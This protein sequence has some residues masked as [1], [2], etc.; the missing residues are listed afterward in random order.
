MLEAAEVTKRFGGLLA[1]RG[2]TLKVRSGEI[3]GL[4]GPN[5]AGKTTLTNVISGVYAPTSGDVKLQGQSLLGL[6]P[7]QISML[8]MLR[9]FQIPKLFGNMSVVENLMVPYLA[10]SP[11][12]A[13]RRT[14]YAEERARQLLELTRLSSLRDIPAKKLSGGEQVLLQVAV[15]FMVENLKCYLLDE[16]FAGINPVLR[17]RVID[18]VLHE[19]N[20]RGTTFLVIS[21][22][23][24]VVR[25]VCSVVSVLADGQILTEGTMDEISANP[26]VINAYLGKAFA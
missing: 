15:G 12:F 20:E 22:E 21:H 4:I 13:W 19:N 6:S 17:E 10:R 25:Q 16:P 18:L 1:N 23:M 26:Q 8:G 24:T 7:F 11:L 14:R 3:R 2:I 9:T 5:G